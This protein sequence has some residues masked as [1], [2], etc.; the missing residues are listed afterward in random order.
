MNL[1][2][3]HVLITGGAKGIGL[4]TAKRILN[5]GA[6]VILWDFKEDDLTATVSDLKEQGY[7]VFSQICDVTNKEQ[8]YQNAEI[9]KEKFG[10]IDI[11]INNAG[12][13]YT[14][15]MLDRTDEELRESYQCQLHIYDLYYSCFYAR[16]VRKKLL[17][18]LLIFLQLLL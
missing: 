6:H 11:L 18:I 14:G 13:V 8:V 5:E 12:T 4:A 7:D 9:I 17:D 16:N 3:K 2:S 1:K 15:Y 10:S